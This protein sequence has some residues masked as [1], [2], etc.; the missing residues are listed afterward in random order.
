[1]FLRRSVDKFAC[2]GAGGQRRAPICPPCAPWSCAVAILHALNFT[3]VARME[4]SAMREQPIHAL[5]DGKGRSRISL[6]LIRATGRA[7]SKQRAPAVASRR[8]GKSACRGADGGQS[9]LA[10]LPTILFATL[11]G[12]QTRAEVRRVSRAVSKARLPA[13]PAG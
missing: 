3:P 13:L 12:G 2:R 6:R 5:S 1:M 10:N 11:H 8:L 7:S 4:S 9:G